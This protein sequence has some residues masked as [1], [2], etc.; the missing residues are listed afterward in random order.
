MDET[1]ETGAVNEQPSTNDQTAGTSDPNQPTPDDRSSVNDVPI[2]HRPYQQLILA[3]WEMMEGMLAQSWS[4]M[5][6]SRLELKKL[7][8]PG[9]FNEKNFAMTNAWLSLIEAMLRCQNGFLDQPVSDLYV[10]EK[11]K[12]EIVH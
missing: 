4:G 9:Q 2:E 8:S 1:H 12:I 5:H 10:P 7:N 3:R 11:K 6:N